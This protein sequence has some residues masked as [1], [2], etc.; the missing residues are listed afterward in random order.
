M[1]NEGE[2][3]SLSHSLNAMEQNIITPEEFVAACRKDGKIYI[4]RLKG[5]EFNRLTHIVAANWLVKAIKGEIPSPLTERNQLEIQKFG[6]LEGT[7]SAAADRAYEDVLANFRR[8]G[9]PVSPNCLLAAEMARQRAML[10]AGVERL[11]IA[12]EIA[13]QAATSPL[14]ECEEQSIWKPVIDMIESAPARASEAILNAYRRRGLPVTKDCKEAAEMIRQEAMR[15]AGVIRQKIANK[16]IEIKN[17]NMGR[18]I[19]ERRRLTFTIYL[20]NDAKYFYTITNENK[21]LSEMNED[22]LF[23]ITSLVKFT[24]NQIDDGEFKERVKRKFSSGIEN[25]EFKNIDETVIQDVVTDVV[26]D[27]INMAV[28]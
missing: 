1:V 24:L 5:Y 23:Y 9:L 21:I 14:T 2:K 6:A 11:A 22:S 18:N 16:R 13:R 10:S 17:E 28:S 19:E 20:N 3:K 7:I 8:R 25:I 26:A 12:A 27:Q 15:S 4:P